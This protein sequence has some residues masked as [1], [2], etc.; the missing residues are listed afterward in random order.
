MTLMDWISHMMKRGF[1]ITHTPPSLFQKAFGINLSDPVPASTE[2]IGGKGDLV[3]LQD[4]VIALGSYAAQL[5]DLNKKRRHISASLEPFSDSGLDMDEIKAHMNLLYNDAKRE[6]LKLSVVTQQLDMSERPDQILKEQI[7]LLDQKIKLARDAAVKDNLTQAA[8]SKTK[9]LIE[10]GKIAVYKARVETK[11]TRLEAFLSELQ[12]GAIRASLE[13]NAQYQQEIATSVAAIRSSFEAVDNVRTHVNLLTE[14]VDKQDEEVPYYIR[15]KEI[16]E[17]GYPIPEPEEAEEPGNPP[18]SPLDPQGD[19][20]ADNGGTSQR[21]LYKEYEEYLSPKERRDMFNK[22][23]EA[24]FSPECE[25]GGNLIRV[26]LGIARQTRGIEITQCPE[27][28]LLVRINYDQ[29]TREPLAC[30]NCKRG[31]R[32]KPINI[33]YSDGN[34]R[35][36]CEECGRYF[37]AGPHLK[38]TTW[39][40]LEKKIK[41]EILTQEPGASQ[42]D[43][44]WNWQQHEAAIRASWAAHRA[45]HSKLDVVE[46]D[47]VNEL[48][49]KQQGQTLSDEDRDKII[50]PGLVR[51]D[52][53]DV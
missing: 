16:W 26:A 53:I 3:L 49:E 13:E 29:R 45:Q 2:N 33:I 35:F 30:P 11:I 42:H 41:D 47:A 28:R 50:K 27:C 23:S 44:S 19:E 17:N 36:L 31:S 12:L 22:I 1:S 7:K 10:L 8:N 32:V 38:P 20:R 46:A 18:Q 37:V 6:A 39:P 34:R 9:Q 51:G 14:S 5:L 21:Q 24:P 15:Y 48:L 4:E 52:I 43:S 40:E 25:C